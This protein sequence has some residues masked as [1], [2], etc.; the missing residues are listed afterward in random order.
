MPPSLRMRA[1]VGFLTLLMPGLMSKNRENTF[2]GGLCRVFTS[3][4]RVRQA[5]YVLCPGR[6]PHLLGL[7]RHFERAKWRRR[8]ATILSR[9]F[10]TLRRR[11]IILKAEGDWP[12][13]FPGFSSTT[14]FTTLSEAEWYPRE[15]WGE[16]SWRRIH[17]LIAFTHFQ[18]R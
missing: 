12:G 16:R 17:G 10:E 13:G 3:F 1:S 15:I 14:L 11:T 2:R 9:I 5:L 8:A 6:E 4:M 18:V 7:I